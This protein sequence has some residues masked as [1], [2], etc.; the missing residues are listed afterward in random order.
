MSYRLE[1]LW[2]KN[3]LSAAKET[4]VYVVGIAVL[5]ATAISNGFCVLPP[6]WQII[7][8]ALGTGGLIWGSFWYAKVLPDSM[9]SES[10]KM[11][12]E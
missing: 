11:N 12:K 3:P 9:K 1:K 5:V 2:S 6:V 7:L 8:L 4:I 10:F